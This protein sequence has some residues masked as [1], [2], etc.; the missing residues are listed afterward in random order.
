MPNLQDGSLEYG[1][2]CSFVERGLPIEYFLPAQTV[3]D[4]YLSH[5]KSLAIDDRTVEAN[6]FRTEFGGLVCT[7]T[8][9]STYTVAAGDSSQSTFR[10]T[11][12]I[13]T[14]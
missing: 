5:M 12:K 7:T 3:P 11:A 13:D 14:N 9:N 8:R 10:P 4:S 6:L 2:S 1:T